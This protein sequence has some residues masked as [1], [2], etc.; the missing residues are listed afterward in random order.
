M[1]TYIFIK[2]LP[3]TIVDKIKLFLLSYGTR[4]ALSIANEL[5]T[6]PY[7][8]SGG[9]WIHRFMNSTQIRSGIKQRYKRKRYNDWGV[10]PLYIIWKNNMLMIE[11]NLIIMYAERYNYS[12]QSIEYFQELL[13]SSSRRKLAGYLTNHVL[14]GFEDDIGKIKN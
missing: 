4:N 14:R 10:L 3:E 2:L 13:S 7:K 8:Y 6:N 11:L 9:L 5:S 1:N 12:E